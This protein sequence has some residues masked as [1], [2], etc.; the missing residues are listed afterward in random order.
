MC[1]LPC[2]IFSNFINVTPC[3]G[4]RLAYRAQWTVFTSYNS[5]PIMFK[6][7]VPSPDAFVAGSFETSLQDWGNYCIA[8]QKVHKH[9]HMQKHTRRRSRWN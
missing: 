2:P 4:I 5:Q 3:T 7:H 1:S 8:S 9:S 6:P